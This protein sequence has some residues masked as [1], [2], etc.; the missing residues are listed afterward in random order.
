M[1]LTV[2]A[3]AGLAFLAG[4]AGA[5]SMR[6]EDLAQGRILITPRQSPDPLFAH[7][8]ILLARYDTTGALGLM[9]Q[10]R[11]NIPVREGLTDY[12]GARKR[13]DT[14]FI[15]GPVQLETILGLARIR[16]P[17]EATGHIAGHSYLVSTRADL[18]TLL[19]TMTAAD[20]RLYAG[21]T[22]WSAGQLQN[23]V[24]RAGW[25]IFPYD[26]N[27]VFDEHPETLWTRLIG[28]TELRPVLFRAPGR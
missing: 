2:L 22:G 3:V 16:T 14:L 10:F 4:T 19:G 1:R 5:Q 9:L 8:V 24:R 26:E 11:G 12:R 28:K 18:E 20:L 27:L 17:R 25:Y 21:Y 7:S 13:E 23:E 6:V 15:G